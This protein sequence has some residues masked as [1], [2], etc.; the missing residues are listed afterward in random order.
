MQLVGGGGGGRQE[1]SLLQKM[2][3]PRCEAGKEPEEPEPTS[4]L[5]PPSSS[6]HGDPVGEPSWKPQVL[7]GS[8][9]AHPTFGPVHLCDYVMTVCPRLYHTPPCSVSFTRREI[10]MSCSLYRA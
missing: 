4:L 8:R 7:Q 10:C 1:Q 6:S 3:P 9:C 2:Q 5:P